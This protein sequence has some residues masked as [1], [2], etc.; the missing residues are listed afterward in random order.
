MDLYVKVL[1]T[2][3]TIRLEVE[4]CYTIKQIKTQIETVLFIPISQQRL[5]CNGKQFE[6]DKTLADYN[7]QKEDFTVHLVVRKVNAS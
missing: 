4:T 3:L 7:C 5:I 2:G 1:P 6:D